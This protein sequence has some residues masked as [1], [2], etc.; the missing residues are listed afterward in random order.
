MFKWGMNLY[1]VRHGK[2][3]EGEDDA[4]RRLTNGGRKAVR[5]VAQRLAGAGIHVD[6]VEH[7]GRVRAA[8]TAE[9]LARSVGAKAKAVPGLDAMDD[10]EPVAERI[11]SVEEDLMLV[12]HLPF[13]ERLGSYL[14]TRDPDA[15]LLHF[16]TAAVACFS[17]SGD[18]WLLEWLLPPDL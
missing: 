11:V 12:G 14:L 10:V 3:E 4:A 15:E 17:R 2:A 7:S 13:M 18:G 8:E 6:R 1:L 16:R 9:I 5:R